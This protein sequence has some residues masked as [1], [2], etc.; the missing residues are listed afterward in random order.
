MFKEA[1]SATAYLNAGVKTFLFV[2]FDGVFNSFYHSGTFPKEYY[3]ADKRE[4]HPNPHY[5]KDV[6]AHYHKMHKTYREPKTYELQW[7]TEFVKEFNQLTSK[8]T[9]QIIWLTTWREHMDDVCSRLEIKSFNEMSFL[10]WGD[11][12]HYHDHSCKF[13][14]LKNYLKDTNMGN[15]QIIWIDDSAIPERI[16]LLESEKT[17]SFPTVKKS[18]FLCIAPHENYGVSRYNWTIVLDFLKEKE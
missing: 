17:A 2:D 13:L 1:L 15:S 9:V 4:R 5:D 8:S 18:N 16:L 11:E 12:F 7:S 10:P 14:S 6:E 3:P